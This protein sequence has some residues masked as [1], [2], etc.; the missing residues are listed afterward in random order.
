MGVKINISGSEIS[1]N[2]RVLN[3]IKA[4]SKSD[5]EVNVKKSEI[6]E[7]AKVMNDISAENGTVRVNIEDM[8]LGKDAEFMNN[9]NVEFESRKEQSRESQ[10]SREDGEN[11]SINK[12]EVYMTTS[13]VKKKK[14][15][16]ERIKDIFKFIKRE[17]EIDDELVT[18][19]RED[20]HKKFEDK[21]SQN[22]KLKGVDYNVAKEIASR[23][24]QQV[25]KEIENE[26]KYR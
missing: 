7:N 9:R 16:F 26:E 10:V 2:S 1:G 24:E 13:M 25:N 11:S 15:L 5:I 12:S 17:N 6:V 14:S 3:G 4:N 21:I 22:G 19:I 8:K 23:E 18:V 20:E